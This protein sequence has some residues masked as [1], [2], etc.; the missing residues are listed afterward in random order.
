MI[1]LFLLAAMATELPDCVDAGA[2]TPSREALVPVAPSDVELLA[3]LVHAEALS[4]GFPEDPDLPRAL[5][6]G[7]VNRVRL[8]DR[9]PSAARSY[10]RGVAGVVFQPGQFNPA[11]SVRSRFRRAFL[12]PTDAPAWGRALA[13]A[14]EA[15][16]RGPDT[17]S[18]VAYARTDAERA[19]DLDLVVNFYYPSSVQARG[20]DAPWEGQ[21]ARVEVT[22]DG[23]P[24][25]AERVRFYRL[26]R[27]PADV[28]R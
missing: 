10:G 23:R 14:A 5:A 19:L 25:P 26:P 11:V 15:L 1:W 7:V 18:P 28:R 24:V 17:A 2:E 6:W 9:S 20:P 27:A 3:R 4:T 16:A 12:C 22:V 13:A 21:L 8:A